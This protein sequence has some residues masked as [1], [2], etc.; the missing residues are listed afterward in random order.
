MDSLL[1]HYPHALRIMEEQSTS[2]RPPDVALRQQRIKAWKP[3][4]HPTWVVGALAI[5][6]V[7]FI[8]TGR[9]NPSFSVCS[10]YCDGKNA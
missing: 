9:S 7:V 5:I 4:L 2:T 6:A 8:P 1:T 10:I 3:I